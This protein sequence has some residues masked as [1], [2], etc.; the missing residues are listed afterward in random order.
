MESLVIHLNRKTYHTS[1]IVKS[2]C[3]CEKKITKLL[4]LFLQ[5][6]NVCETTENIELFNAAKIVV[7]EIL[8]NFQRN[9]HGAFCKD[10]LG[11]HTKV[12]L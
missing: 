11:L 4:L 7:Y 6:Q 3:L 1:V 9:E 10:Q 12:E 8:N 2:H 5:N